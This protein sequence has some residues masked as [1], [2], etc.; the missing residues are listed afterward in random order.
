MLIERDII[1]KLL[2]TTST[3]NLVGI[4][5]ELK[6]YELALYMLQA[7]NHSEQYG[8]VVMGV[9]K[10]IDSYAIEGVSSTIY[11]RAEEPISTA[12]SLISHE[13]EVEYGNVYINGKNIFVIMLKNSEEALSLGF[14]KDLDSQGAFVKNVVRAC[15]NLQARKLYSNSSEDERN[16]YIGDILGAIGYGVKDQTRRGSS[17]TGKDAGEVDIFVSKD[18]FPFTVIEAMNLDSVN[19]SYINKHIDKVFLYDTSGNRFNICLSYVK[20][21]DFASFWSNYA[22]HVANYSYDVPLLSSDTSIDNEYGYSEVKIMKTV[23]NRSGRTVNLYHI[24][25]RIH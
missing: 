24:C 5:M 2:S 19:T 10:T 4:G 12:L 6:P 17:S 20:V 14:T 18:G 15:L 23:H 7:L 9:T 22:A 25:V 16:D 13:I 21:A 1:G 3:K 11:E 8:Y